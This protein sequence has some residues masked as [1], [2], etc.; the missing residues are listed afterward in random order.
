MLLRF[1]QLHCIR[2]I[3]CCNCV[4]LYIS[5]KLMYSEVLL[6][7]W[8]HP[9]YSFFKQGVSMFFRL[10]LNSRY[11]PGW[12]QTHSDPPA[13]ASQLLSLSS[14]SSVSTQ[15]SDSLVKYHLLN[16]FIV[17]ICFMA[18]IFLW[19]FITCRKYTLS[20]LIQ[21]LS[22]LLNVSHFPNFLNN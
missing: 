19:D 1:Y 5:A 7:T 8:H 12:P 22:M 14:S 16:W 15:Y 4:V 11:M 9:S 10:V 18:T 2:K 20:F 17:F 21:Y 3:S 13:S 6:V